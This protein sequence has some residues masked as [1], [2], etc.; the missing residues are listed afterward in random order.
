M[1]YKIKTI[2]L[3]WWTA[4]SFPESLTH[5]VFSR[6]PLPG[7]SVRDWR[8]LQ[9][10]IC[11]VHDDLKPEDFLVCQIDAQ[12][13]FIKISHMQKLDIIANNSVCKVVLMMSHQ[14]SC[15]QK[16]TSRTRNKCNGPYLQKPVTRS[17]I[18]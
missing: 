12:K 3:Q 6:L 16:K 5:G 2:E 15:R 11:D 18:E 14:A 9:E 17:S 1:N 8:H 7:E 4:D 10:T 13:Y